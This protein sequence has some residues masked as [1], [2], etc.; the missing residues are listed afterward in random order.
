MF[1]KVMWSGVSY[2]TERQ[3]VPNIY[4]NKMCVTEL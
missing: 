4:F 1:M 3:S 2:F